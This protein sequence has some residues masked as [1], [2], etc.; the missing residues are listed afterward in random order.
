VPDR[1]ALFPLS[2]VLYP[3]G[4]LPLHVFEERY[5]VLVDRLVGLPDGSDRSFG[6]V[7]IRVGRES[8]VD[9]VSALHQVGCVADLREVQAH[10]DGRYDIL[11][12]GSRR[13][14]LLGVDTSEPYLQGDVQWLDEPDGEAAALL[15]AR[16]LERFA[17]YRDALHGLGLRGGD[18]DLPHDSRRL[19]YLVATSMVLDL[20]DHQALL[21]APD[22]AAR[23][24]LELDLLR[25]EEA[26]ITHLPSLPG[27]DYARQPAL[28]N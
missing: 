28:P 22:A 24:R 12:I 2:A 3:G 11:T 26:L 14:R 18:G 13:F 25:R 20:A 23:L 17:G 16:V 15:A 19:S 5:R 27:V 7:A 9:G 1:I 4:R 6:V 21:A 10:P 8:G